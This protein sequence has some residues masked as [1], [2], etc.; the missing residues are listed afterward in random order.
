V[1]F[2]ADESVDRP[3]YERLRRDG[4]TVLAIAERS[5]GATDPQVL[6]RS[7]QLKAVLLT[8]DTD[9]GELVFRQG[10]ASAGVLLVRLSG[11]TAEQKA[12]VVAS[13]VA[14]HGAEL[15]ES[16]SV[17]SPGTVRIR[18]EPQAT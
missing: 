9:F 8:A 3:I 1:N 13:A 2:V 16:F 7:V 5:P 12:E 15:P 18:R 6:E 10:Q 4:H 14:A 17:V 11:L